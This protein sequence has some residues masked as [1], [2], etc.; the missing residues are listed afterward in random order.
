MKK[1][2]RKLVLCRETVRTLAKLDLMLAIGGANSERCAIAFDTG[3]QAC[4]APHAAVL[5]TKPGG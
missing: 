5:T 4:E 2:S 1:T 3:A